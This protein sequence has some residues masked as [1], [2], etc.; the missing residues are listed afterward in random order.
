[1]LPYRGTRRGGIGGSLTATHEQP[2]LLPRSLPGRWS[3]RAGARAGAGQ[4][5][6]SLRTVRHR[7]RTAATAV[8]TRTLRHSAPVCPPDG[9]ATA[10]TLRPST[11]SGSPGG[12]VPAPISGRCR[13]RPGGPCG[14]DAHSAEPPS[15]DRILPGITIGDHI[16]LAGLANGF[17]TLAVLAALRGR[18]N[19][20]DGTANLRVP[21]RRT[22]RVVPEHRPPLA[23]SSGSSRGRALA[24]QVDVRVHGGF[25][26][27][28]GTT[29]HHGTHTPVGDAWEPAPLPAT[30][31]WP[32]CSNPASR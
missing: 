10:C 23:C 2:P 8:S 13:L 14:H 28:P 9:G 19:P 25:L 22:A 32:V 16:D 11:S 18:S 3:S 29:T 15:R 20:A 12:G 31:P 17:H 30:C 26:I 6:P 5:T 24:C 27:A 1:M 7:P 21:R 4:S